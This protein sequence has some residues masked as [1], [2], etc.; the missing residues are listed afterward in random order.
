VENS[1]AGIRKKKAQ[2]YQRMLNHGFITS[3]DYERMVGDLGLPPE[4]KTPSPAPQS[5]APTAAPTP[6]PT[7]APKPAAAPAANR[8]AS[9]ASTAR[10][11]QAA[12]D[13]IP[14]G[15]TATFRNGQVWTKNAAGQVTQIQPQAQ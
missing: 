4:Q 11:P 14:P 9:A 8:P 12:L 2:I 7:P 5:H 10:P 15:Q 3:D 1:L 6:A 13:A